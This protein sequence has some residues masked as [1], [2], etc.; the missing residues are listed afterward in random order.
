MAVVRLHHHDLI[1]ASPYDGLDGKT[2]QM[3]NNGSV[4]T[5]GAVWTKEQ[6]NVWDEEW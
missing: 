6:S 5:E 1:C 2:I 3:Q 4:S